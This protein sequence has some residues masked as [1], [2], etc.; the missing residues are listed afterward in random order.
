MSN[1]HHT[2]TRFGSN[3]RR[4]RQAAGLSQE[5]LAGKADLD[6]TYISGI[7][8]GLL[9]TLIGDLTFDRANDPLIHVG[10]LLC[11]ISVTAFFAHERI[12]GEIFVVQVN[13]GIRPRLSSTSQPVEHLPEIYAVEFEMKF[14]AH[15][16]HNYLARFAAAAKSFL[17]EGRPTS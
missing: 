5:A 9:S 16:G 12:I 10:N 1:R 14:F 4:H 6:R 2:L 11:F 3:V 8:R 17:V 13:C 7:E 15:D